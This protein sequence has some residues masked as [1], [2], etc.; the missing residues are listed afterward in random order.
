MLDFIDKMNFYLMA[1]V[2]F[3]RS[4]WPEVR[5]NA[6]LFVG[7]INTVLIYMYIMYFI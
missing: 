6:A 5:S 2:Q 1:A 4:V 3:F 7:M